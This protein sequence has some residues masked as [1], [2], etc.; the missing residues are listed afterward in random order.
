MTDPQAARERPISPVD[1]LSTEPELDKENVS[2]DII[3]VQA[4][5]SVSLTAYNTSRV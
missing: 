5:L 4:R 3:R 2:E 1:H